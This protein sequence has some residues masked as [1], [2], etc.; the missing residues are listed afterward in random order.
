MIK[1]EKVIC[2]GGIIINNNGKVVVVNQNHDSWSLPKGHVDDGETLLDAAIREIYEETGIQNPKFIKPIGSFGR[3]RIGLDGNDDLSHYKTIHIFLF[4]SD[5][6]KL[7]PIDKNNPEA[8]WLTYKE[9]EKILTHPNDK[10][11]FKEAIKSII[12][13]NSIILITGASGEIGENLIDYFQIDK[14]KII[15]I[16]I[17]EPKNQ[18]NIFK[19]IKGS[20]LNIEILN[21]INEEYVIEEIY[22]LAAVLS[23]KAEQNKKLAQNVNIDGTNNL[24]NLALSQNLK[25]NIITKFF[26]QVQLLFI[27]LKNYLIPVSENKFCNPKTIYGQHKLFCENLGIAFDKYG[28]NQNFKIDFRSIRFPGIISINSMPSGGTSDYAPK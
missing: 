27:M 13:E 3:Y 25:N 8:K 22:H 5:Q 15:A 28:N 23:T 12:N 19:F 4:E 10:K 26:F 20:I 11:F 18:S 21:E 24:F 9:A 17:N 14:R 7:I 1:T 6:I 16:D 2:A